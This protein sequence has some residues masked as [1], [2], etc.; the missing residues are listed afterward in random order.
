MS[1]Q[2]YDG[3]NTP[4]YWDKIWAAEGSDTWRKYPRCFQR[5]AEIVPRGASVLDVGCGVGPLLKKLR[6]GAPRELWG[7]D[8]SPVAIDILK[9]DGIPGSVAKVPPIPLPDNSYDVVVA[10]ETFEHVEDD[11]KLFRE[12]C[13][14]ARKLVIV[15]VP[16]DGFGPE[17]TGEHVRAYNTKSLLALAKGCAS[18]VS[19]EQFSEGFNVFVGGPGGPCLPVKTIIMVASVD[20][21]KL[22]VPPRGC[23]DNMPFVGLHI[24]TRRG[25]CG[26]SLIEAVA[27]AGKIA[28]VN[29]WPSLTTIVDYARNTT[30]RSLMNFQPPCDYILKLDDDHQ[31]PPNVLEQLMLHDK[32]VVGGV[33]M[34]REQIG[35]PIY[36]WTE[37][38]EN[39]PDPARTGFFRVDKVATGCMLIKR[40]VFEALPYPWFEHRYVWAKNWRSGEKDEVYGEDYEFCRKARQAG[41]E[42]WADSTLDI[43]HLGAD[44][45]NPWLIPGLIRQG[46]ELP[47]APQGV[48]VDEA[49][50]GCNTG[51]PAT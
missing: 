30:V 42:I 18:D 34:T 15:A 31:F 36:G 49:V 12:A 29:I 44:I 38:I 8:I 48:V 11:K 25:T 39:P 21:N 46:A 26:V 32:D 5:I 22:R 9:K 41:F 27:N 2:P 43:S 23:M 17:V 3:C 13:R 33:Y 20:G 28:Q 51:P 35:R 1:T 16:D 14:V 45:H 19:V 40:R 37:H 47:K 50:G 24:C 4:G 7:M 10:T 6:C